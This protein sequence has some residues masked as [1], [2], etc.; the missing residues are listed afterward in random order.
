M[1]MSHST[2]REILAGAAVTL[3]AAPAF[4]AG[5][6]GTA[7]K[8]PK[9]AAADALC[10]ALHAEAKAPALSVAVARSDGPLWSAAYGRTN[11]EL[12][13]TA[14][15]AHLF[16]LG[17]VS[18]VLTSTLAARLVSRGVIDLD[19]PI[20]AW[21]PDLPTQ[22]RQTSL[23][24][25]LTHRGGVRHYGP[26][27]FD[28]SGPGGPVYMR[29]YPSNREVLDLFIN[30]PLVAPPGSRVSYS[31]YGFTLASIVMEKA[32]NRPFVEMVKAEI[33]KSFGLASLVEDDPFALTPQ[34]ATGYLIGSDLAIL[35][36][37]LPVDIRPKLTDGLANIPFSNPAYCW[38]GAGFLITA[39]DCARFGAMLLESPGS[40]ISAAERALLFTPMTEGDR[41]SP[42]LG[43]AWR[44]DADANGRR[45]YHH[46]GA[47]IGGRYS[48][49]IYPDLGLSIALASNVMSAPGDV[50]KPSATLADAFASSS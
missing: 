47:T 45:R 14:S 43:L 28:L 26:R 50:L 23:R 29:I 19:A 2:R 10:R 42:P 46:A 37:G 49:V 27:D 33:G 41:S 38:A 7:R 1:S 39:S 24:Q 3:A 12:G 34:R 32:A 9:N 40:R 36:G 8:A 13:V 20:S 6:R 17:S 18:K 30:D 35:Y 15:E 4:T 48:L 22:H 21:L 16:R 31:S 44:V 25:L 5:M 11:L